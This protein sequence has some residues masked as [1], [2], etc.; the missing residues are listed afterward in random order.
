MIEQVILNHLNKCLTV[1]AYMEKPQNN[2]PLRYVLIEK[3]GSRRA[4]HIKLSAFA[5]QSYAESLFEAAKLNEEVKK[6]M[7]N[8]AELNEIS[9]AQLNS[10]YNFTN[11]EKKQY[12][13]QAI[14]DITHY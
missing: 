9:R 7:D 6:A 12:R 8:S 14:Y 5:I 4:N 10:D 1:P 11:T 2:I 13:Y 3:T